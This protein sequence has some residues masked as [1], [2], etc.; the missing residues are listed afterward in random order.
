MRIIV[1]LFLLCAVPCFG[2]LRADLNSDGR[3]NFQDLAILM[4]EWMQEETMANNC[5]Y[6]DEANYGTENQGYIDTGSQFQSTLRDSFAITAWCKPHAIGQYPGSLG[7][8]G[9]GTPT[10]GVLLSIQTDGK[11]YAHYSTNDQLCEIAEGPVLVSDNWYFVAAVY[12]NISPTTGQ[13]T[14]YINGVQ[15]AQSDVVTVV[16]GDFVS[17]NLCLGMYNLSGI[18]E[19]FLG[20]IDD[21]RIYGAANLLTVED[22]VEIYSKGVGIKYAALSNGKTAVAAWNCDGLIG[23]KLIDAVGGLEGTLVGDIRL[24]PGGVPFPPNRPRPYVFGNGLDSMG[25]MNHR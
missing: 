3:V 20:I 15:A 17:P 2:Q 11:L 13:V 19:P 6:F 1:C 21:I 23:G 25:I 12:R 5:L 7:I 9:A 14:T 8:I 10:T 4:S 22:M 24:I 18:S 16:F